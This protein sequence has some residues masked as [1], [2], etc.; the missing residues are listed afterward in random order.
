MIREMRELISKQVSYNPKDYYI[1]MNRI[2]YDNYGNLLIKS[3]H[4]FVSK[5]IKEFWDAGIEYTFKGL[6]IYI[7]NRLQ[8]DE[9]ILVKVVDR[10]KYNIKEDEDK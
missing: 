4:G 6:P 10:I 5:K 7:D 9:I 2:S 1:F 3:L 8:D